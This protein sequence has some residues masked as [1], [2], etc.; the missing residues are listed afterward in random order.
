LKLP[1]LEAVVERRLLVNYRIDADIA[2]RLL[3]APFRPELVDGWAVGGIC[4]IRLGRLRPRGAPEVLGL[5]SENA[6]HRIAVE[7]DTAA[8]IRTGV[9]IPRRDTGSGLNTFLGGRVF[10]G[11]HHRA[12]FR[13]HETPDE[14]H[15]AFDSV[16][17]TASVEVSVELAADLGPSRLFGDVD[18]ASRFFQNDSVGYSATRRCDQFEGL[19][20]DTEAWRVTPVHLIAARSS[21]FDDPRRF[22]IGTAT[23][24]CAL[25]MRDMPVRWHAL[26]AL[27]SHPAPSG[28]IVLA[29]AGR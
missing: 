27:D 13:V 25:L 9:Y 5:R 11:E 1:A 15:V 14:L 28:P 21:F 29:E 18:Q 12:R 23:L 10:P 8:G 4:L 16:D 19:E 26:D 20:L 24:D 7:W 2:A 22:P 6:A 17:G 3:P